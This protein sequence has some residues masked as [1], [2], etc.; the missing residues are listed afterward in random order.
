MVAASL[1]NSQN[2]FFPV[3][4]HGQF[5]DACAVA[6]IDAFM[7]DPTAPVDTSCVPTTITFTTPLPLT[8][9]SEDGRAALN[10]T[11]NSKYAPYAAQANTW[12]DPR[13]GY[14]SIAILPA[15]TTPDDA[16]KAI[17]PDAEITDG[18]EIAGLPSRYFELAAGTESARVFA[19]ADDNATY[20]ITADVLAPRKAPFFFGYELDHYLDSVTVGTGG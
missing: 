7:I 20:R 11:L 4:G 17:K 14:F 15:G 3:G 8:V 5:Q 13:L 1:P 6:I 19:F 9:T 18:R 16:L 10:M 2:T 12:L